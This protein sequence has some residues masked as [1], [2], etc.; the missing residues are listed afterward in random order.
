MDQSV[1]SVEF[2]TRVCIVSLHLVP[3]HS[4]SQISSF[5]F[6]Q[7]YDYACNH[8]PD[9]RQ[10]LLACPPSTMT[11]LFNSSPP[12]AA[13]TPLPSSGH[14]SKTRV[15]ARGAARPRSARSAVGSAVRSSA[16]AAAAQPQQV[17]AHVHG[18]I[19]LFI[20]CSGSEGASSSAVVH[21][22]AETPASSEVGA[23]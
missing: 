17:I 10:M 11:V 5:R 9:R 23:V 22:N 21:K 8:P 20:L 4:M 2:S 1:N 3:T 6:S 7:R 13:T 19:S 16:A 12:F 15:D 18:D 14:S